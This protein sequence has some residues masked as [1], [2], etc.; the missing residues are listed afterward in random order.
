MPFGG[1]GAETVMVNEPFTPS[2]VA[3]ITADPAATALS[4][5]DDETVATAM[6]L[7]LQAIVR[8]VR[9]LLLASLVVAVS[10]VVWPTLSDVAPLT[11]TDAT[12]AGG[13]A[14]T[15]RVAEPVT[16]SLVARIA[17]L[18]AATAVTKP[19]PETVAIAVLALAQVTTRPE[20]N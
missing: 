8:P 14:F 5:P 9:T 10:C 12:G 19:L 17:T 20:S 3:V 13:G 15:V 1:G 2:L 11:V 16:P 18:P 7:E 6:L 4:T